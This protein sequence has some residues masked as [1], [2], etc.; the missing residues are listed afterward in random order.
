MK[1]HVQLGGVGAAEAV[2]MEHP[3]EGFSSSLDLFH[4]L[5]LFFRGDNESSIRILVEIAEDFEQRL[6]L[7]SIP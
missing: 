7:R 5:P 2:R 4:D 6:P 1:R 3:Y